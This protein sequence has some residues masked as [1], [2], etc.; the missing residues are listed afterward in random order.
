MAAFAQKV[1]RFGPAVE[2]KFSPAL[3]ECRALFLG[4]GVTAA[5]SSHFGGQSGYQLGLTGLVTVGLAS[6]V[7]RAS[8]FLYTLSVATQRLATFGDF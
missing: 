7:H 6:V 3:D 1:G 5:R 4:G 2:K 8:F